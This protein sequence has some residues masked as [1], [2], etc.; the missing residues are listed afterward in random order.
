MYI[1]RF[2][3]GFLALFLSA[4]TLLTAQQKDIT[5]ED[6][7][8]G[9]F[10]QERMESLRSLD[11]GKEYAVLNFDRAIG[12][13]AIDV[14]SYETG[15]KTRTILNSANL[16]EIDYF[17]GYEFSDN[18]QKLILGT[19][20]ESIYRRSTRGIFY[21]Y[22]LQSKTLKK[23]SEE[24]IKE[25][26]L[27][28]TGEKVAFVFENNI[29]VKDLASAEVTQVTRDGEIN[30]II[31]GVTDWVY[32]EEFGFVRAFQWNEDSDKIAFLRF[33]ETDVPEFSM[34][35]YGQELYQTQTVFKYPKAGEA[36][37]IVSLH[38][39]DLQNENT[40]NIDLG[41]YSDFYIPRIKW[42]N[43]RRHPECPGAKPPSERTRA[44]LYRCSHQGG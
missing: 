25:P 41:D 28:P 5:L 16:E 18:E 37:S 1:M 34:D 33:D 43:N 11:N 8:G 4:T 32:E 10:R 35:V 13:S 20:V 40:S 2:I 44:F 23:I 31:N 22:D 3:Q 27:S 39:Y 15:N 7:W 14:Y 12:T 6:I 19:E 17:S 24:K 21:V 30:K 36:N 9:T 42:T 29:Y 38:I 26:T